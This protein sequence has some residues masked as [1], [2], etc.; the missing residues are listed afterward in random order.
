MKQTRQ[1]TTSFVSSSYLLVFATLILILC[2]CNV[3]QQTAGQSLHV[4]ATLNLADKGSKWISASFYGNIYS[5]LSSSILWWGTL[6][7][8]GI[9]FGGFLLPTGLNIDLAVILGYGINTKNGHYIVQMVLYSKDPSINNLAFV[10]IDL[11]SKTYE[12]ELPLVPPV[13]PNIDWEV[14]TSNSVILD[15]RDLYFLVSVDY[16]LSARNIMGQF[17]TSMI[18]NLKEAFDSEYPVTNVSGA[19]FYDKYLFV[20]RTGSL[21]VNN[22]Q[23]SQIIQINVD[24]NAIFPSFGNMYFN[25]VTYLNSNCYNMFGWGNFLF[26]QQL[27]GG[28]GKLYGWDFINKVLVSDAVSILNG[29][30]WGTAYGVNNTIGQGLIVSGD[31]TGKTGYTAYAYSLQGETLSKLDQLTV[32]T[33]DTLPVLGL[34]AFTL[35]GLSVLMAGHNATNYGKMTLLRYY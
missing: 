4:T 17:N 7:D 18:L 15:A 14:I 23:R 12:V 30:S 32:T 5:F 9:D 11:Y 35:P 29:Q 13:P 24:T 26:W 34:P 2:C 21:D 10:V 19:I 31:P 25:H 27:E 33:G 3:I 28:V 8:K 1:A 20:A 22:N 16:V 6:D